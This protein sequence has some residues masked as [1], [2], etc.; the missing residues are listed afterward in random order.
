[1]YSGTYHQRLDAKGRVAL[2]ARLREELVD[3]DPRPLVVTAWQRAVWLYGPE[4]WR[5]VVEQAS[6][7]PSQNRAVSRF[8]RTFFGYAA[9]VEPDAQGRILLPA[10]LRSLGGLVIKPPMQNRHPRPQ[11]RDTSRRKD[12]P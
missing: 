4:E 7:M 2:P 10:T 5:R 3:G 6:E 8:I 12:R 9:E 1:V 11:P